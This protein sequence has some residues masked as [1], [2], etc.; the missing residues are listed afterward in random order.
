MQVDSSVS[1]EQSQYRCT[2]QTTKCVVTVSFGLCRL[3]SDACSSM[4]SLDPVVFE[5]AFSFVLVFPPPRGSGEG[6]DCHFPR[7]IVGFEADSGPGPGENYLL[8]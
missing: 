3:V 1:L 8:F 6:S 2:C 5:D 4:C 7:E